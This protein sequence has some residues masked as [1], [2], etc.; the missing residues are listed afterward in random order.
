MRQRRRLDCQGRV[1]RRDPCLRALLMM[2]RHIF[3]THNQHLPVLLHHHT[4]QWNNWLVKSAS[5]S[6]RV[7]IGLWR[8]RHGNILVVAMFTRSF[9]ETTSHYIFIKFYHKS[10][11]WKHRSMDYFYILSTVCTAR[12]PWSDICWQD[13]QFIRGAHLRHHDLICQG[14]ICLRDLSIGCSDDEHA[15][16]HHA[17]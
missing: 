11:T 12:P 2:K 16:F 1:C 10:P 17:Q 13:M 4:I 5:Y 14:Q 3:T 8:T 7:R 9:S 6:S 15:D